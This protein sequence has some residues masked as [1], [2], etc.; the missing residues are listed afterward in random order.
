MADPFAALGFVVQGLWVIGILAVMLVGARAAFRR[1]TGRRL[2]RVADTV[3]AA[4][5]VGVYPATLRVQVPESLP[6]D[7]DRSAE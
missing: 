1:P 3:S 5:A 7:E 4:T 6:P 2:R